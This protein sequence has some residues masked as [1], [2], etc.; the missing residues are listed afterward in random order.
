MAITFFLYARKSSESEERQVLSIEAQISELRS[1]AEKERLVIKEDF[2]EAMTAKEPGRPIFNEMIRRIEKGEAQGVVTWHPDRLARNSIDGGRIV[3]LL[4]TGHIKALK[5]PTFWFEN[6]PQGKFMLNI[7][8]GQSKYYVDNLSENVKRGIRQKLRNGGW[9][10]P[11]PFG[12]I[13][14]KAVKTIEIDPINGPLIAKMFETYATGEYNLPQLKAEI[15][16]WG[17]VSRFNRKATISISHIQKILKTAF[18]YGIVS[19]SGETFQGK[20]PALTTKEIFDRVQFIMANRGRNH[21]ERKHEFAFSG[22]A[23]CSCGAAITA[24]IQKGHNY[25]HCTRKKGPCK[26]PYVREELLD[27]QV[28]KAIKD[29][30]IPPEAYQELV[31]LTEQDRRAATHSRQEATD[32]LK[33]PLAE[34]QIKLEKLLDLLLAATISQHEYNKKKEELLDQKVALEEKLAKVIESGGFWFEPMEEFFRAAHQAHQLAATENLAAKRNFLKMTGSNFRISGRT[35]SFSCVF[36][37]PLIKN[38]AP[39]THWLGRMDSNHRYQVQSLVTCH[40]ST[41]QKFC[42]RKIFGTRQ[43]FSGGPTIST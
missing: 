27:Q 11:A 43:R 13:N 21:E 37:W 31:K 30:S 34:I 9:P 33:K 6:T 41:P 18:Y 19:V 22:F 28:T 24:E 25:Y 3:Y 4:D 10:H 32:A 29:V 17:L 38:S 40:L 5:C 2:I 8:F 23:T 42:Y 15:S 35:L 7:A 1:Y 12:Y 16:N 26:E 20:H 36:P 39:I 14:K